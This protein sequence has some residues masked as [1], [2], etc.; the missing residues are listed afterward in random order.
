[1]RAI[2]VIVIVVIVL[3]FYTL[4]AKTS[5]YDFLPTPNLTDLD[6]VSSEAARVFGVAMAMINGDSSGLDK[7]HLNGVDCESAMLESRSADGLIILRLDDVQATA[8]RDIA[9][10]IID[11]SLGR[12]MPI[13]V[14]VIPKDI[15]TDTVLVDY[16]RDNRDNQALE[17][18][19]HGTTHAAQEY[20]NISRQD[21]L[22]MVSS[23][24]ETLVR[25]LGVNPVT[26]IPP[27]NIYNEN[28]TLALR[29]LGFSVISAGYNEFDYDANPKKIGHSTS[30][31]E[32][33]SVDSPG[34]LVSPAD[35]VESCKE[36][37]NPLNVCVI[38][39]HPQDYANEDGSLD[40]A[41]YAYFIQMLDRFES[42]EFKFLTFRDLV[43]CSKEAP[44]SP[45]ESSISSLFAGIESGLT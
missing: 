29:D 9:I 37:S 3:A 33:L 38:M 28:T 17:V 8:W 41:K 13:T 11:D 18:A 24:K 23:G 34:E 43:S 10:R 30:T 20:A 14:G 36:V 44:D 5:T 2:E 22:E 19:Q 25:T 4:I 40:E 27:Y 26:F 15:E 45:T 32:A 42:G 1:M 12:Q 35:I 16:L 31:F 7:A 21:A 39:I 6:E